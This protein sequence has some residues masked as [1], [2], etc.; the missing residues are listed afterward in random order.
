MEYISPEVLASGFF[1]LRNKIC[2]FRRQ[3]TVNIKISS[4]VLDLYDFENL[5]ILSCI[6][7]FEFKF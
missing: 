3:Q 1:V 2:H 6:F 5:T 4:S 7:L